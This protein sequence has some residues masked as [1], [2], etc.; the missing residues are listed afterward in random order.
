MVETKEKEWN[1]WGNEKVF[2]TESKEQYYNI[3]RTEIIAYM[4]EVTLF[5]IPLPL[6]VKVYKSFLF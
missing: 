1:D 4:R 2:S 5:S 3:K 6:H